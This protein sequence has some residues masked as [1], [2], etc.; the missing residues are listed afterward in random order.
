MQVG[1][2]MLTINLP[3]FL[4]VE[5]NLVNATV[6]VYLSRSMNEVTESLLDCVYL[7][8]SCIVI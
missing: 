8:S 6:T 2:L 7:V 1:L 3:A 4:M 5:T